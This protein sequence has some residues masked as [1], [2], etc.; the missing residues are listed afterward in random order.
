MHH[1]GG[2]GLAL[3]EDLGTSPSFD[4]LVDGVLDILKLERLA[5]NNSQR[6]MH[7]APSNGCNTA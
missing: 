7:A 5:C 2:L 1:L 6:E 3:Q 4:R